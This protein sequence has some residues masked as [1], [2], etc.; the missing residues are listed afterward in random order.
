MVRV[1]AD[2]DPQPPG[3]SA[4]AA[5]P[6]T[7]SSSA[8]SYMP[9]ARIPISKPCSLRPAGT[10]CDS[11]NMTSRAV[12]PAPCGA[13]ETVIGSPPLGASMSLDSATGTLSPSAAVVS[14]KADANCSVPSLGSITSV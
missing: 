13:T 7:N 14:A 8:P 11:S 9:S 10:V 5:M 3:K 4:P 6:T 1:S 2:T 12:A